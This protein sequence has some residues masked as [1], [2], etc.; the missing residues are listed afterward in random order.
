MTI[1]RYW[2]LLAAAG[3]QLDSFAL[4]NQI[5]IERRDCGEKIQ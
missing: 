3:S 1:G 4:D 5:K 2:Q